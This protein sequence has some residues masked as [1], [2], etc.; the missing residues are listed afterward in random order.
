[1]SVQLK[2]ISVCRVFVHEFLLRLQETNSSDYITLGDSG[3]AL[4]KIKYDRSMLKYKLHKERQGCNRFDKTISE[5]QKSLTDL[6]DRGVTVQLDVPLD[7]W[8]KPSVEISSL[9][10]QCY[11]MVS[12]FEDAL[13]D[14][15]Y[16]LQGEVDLLDYFCRD[17]VLKD[18]PK[19]Q[20]P[21]IAYICHSFHSITRT[22]Q[23]YGMRKVLAC[24]ILI[25]D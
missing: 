17:R 4:R 13:E 22:D 19:A 1:M 24:V 25:Q 16:N 21:R 18:F 8:D 5:T 3:V 7:M 11:S 15:F 14:W 10:K 12:A 2:D 23:T 9:T 6:A 20:G